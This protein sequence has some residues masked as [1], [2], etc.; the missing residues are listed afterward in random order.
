MSYIP[1]SLSLFAGGSIDAENISILYLGLSKDIT[2][3]KKE[4][5]F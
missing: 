5:L 4:L 2:T 1:N 3:E